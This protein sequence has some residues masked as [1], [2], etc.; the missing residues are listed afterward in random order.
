MDRLGAWLLPGLLAGVMAGIGLADAGWLGLGL[1]GVLI[2]GACGTALA[3][4][5]LPQRTF[6]VAA[7]AAACVV[8]ITLGGVRGSATPKSGPADVA[9]L[10]P[11][12]TVRVTG[13]VADDP[14]PRG[15]TENVVLDAVSRTGGR[16][17]GS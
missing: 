10:P 7:V 6:A 8:G 1:A 2:L 4:L 16:G 3:A 9:A 5:V 15:T 11:G 13:V 17:M 12:A 14:V